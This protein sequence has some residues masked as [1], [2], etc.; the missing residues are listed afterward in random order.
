MWA[1]DWHDR[2]WCMPSAQQGSVPLSLVELAQQPTAMLATM[3]HP[4]PLVATGPNEQPVGQWAP[5][6]QPRTES[7]QPVSSARRR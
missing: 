5:G 2:W 6:P 4:S 1:I 7:P 3:S